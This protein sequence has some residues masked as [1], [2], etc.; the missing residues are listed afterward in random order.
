MGDPRKGILTNTDPLSDDPT[1]IVSLDWATGCIH[2]RG[3]LDRESA[4]HLRDAF[5]ALLVTDHV[6]WTIDASE[7]TFCD[8]GG[9]RALAAAARTATA[10]G[11]ELRLAAADRC[12]TRLLTLT[13][14]TGL[15]TDAAVPAAVRS[16][17]PPARRPTGGGSP[18]TPV[19]HMVLR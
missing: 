14:L 19:R 6:R 9:L 8:A 2:L 15:F 11:R 17:A 13:G 12:L 5:A 4:H 18:T 1:L 3:D 10:A 16:P 7:L